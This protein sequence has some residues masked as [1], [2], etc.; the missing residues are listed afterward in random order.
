MSLAVVA[1][2]MWGSIAAS[3]CGV[4]GKLAISGRSTSSREAGS[5]RKKKAP[6]C[7]SLFHSTCRRLSPATFALGAILAWY[8]VTL[9]KTLACRR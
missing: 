4:V 7:R 9:A 1:T 3:G 6:P 2:A 8:A 5:C